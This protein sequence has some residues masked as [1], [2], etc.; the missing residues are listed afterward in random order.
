M[1]LTHLRNPAKGLNQQRAGFTLIELMV[2]ITII[3]ILLTMTLL[4][5][6]FSQESDRVVSAAQQVKSFLEGARDRA[7]Y[8]KEPRGVRFFVSSENPRAVTTMAYI[9]PGG[10]WSSPDNS[11]NVD[12]LRV[13]GNGD[14]R[15]DNTADVIRR[16]VGRNNPGWWNLK[17]RGWLVDGMRIRI[18]KGPTGTWYPL[19]TSSINLAVA[20]TDVQTLLLQVP[21]A[22]A[23]NLGQELAHSNL[24]YEI[25]LPA[26][27]LPIDPG[28]LP[29]DVSLSLDASKVPSAWRPLPGVEPY[30]GFMDVVFSPRGNVIGDAAGVGLLHL[31]V[32][33]SEDSRFLLERFRA[34]LRSY[35]TQPSGPFPHEDL[36]LANVGVDSD[37]TFVPLDEIDASGTVFVDWTGASG[38]YV[39]KDRRYVSIFS[40]T[41]NVIIQRVNAFTGA[42]DIED[43]FDIDNDSNLSEPDGLA[44]DPYAFAES[45]RVAN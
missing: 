35:G 19:D 32:G 22:D 42:P 27:M 2:V 17:R 28:I 12:L 15:F 26:K 31:Y 29:Q 36:F 4:A 33:D 39:T 23:G 30:S 11:G 44:D 9:A 6:N 34:K 21:Y 1:N 37:R 14:T 16:V 8:A 38:T 41:G 20:P 40:Q 43:P 13:D 3:I 45:G 7:M 24:S 18:P 5:V 10:A 25:E